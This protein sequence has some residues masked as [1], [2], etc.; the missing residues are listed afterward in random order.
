MTTQVIT[1]MAKTAGSYLF[2]LLKE[3]VFSKAVNQ[4]DVLQAQEKAISEQL[5]QLSQQVANILKE[6]KKDNEFDKMWGPV[7]HLRYYTERMEGCLRSADRGILTDLEKFLGDIR[8][9]NDGI[10]YQMATLYDALRGDSQ[11]NEFGGGIIKWWVSASYEAEVAKTDFT[12]KAFLDAVEAKLLAI[13][14]II[15][16][17]AVLLCTTTDDPK[18]AEKMAQDWSNKLES[19][20][21]LAWNNFPPAIKHFQ[22]S[23]SAPFDTNPSR[24]FRF[25]TFGVGPHDVTG[26]YL[27]CTSDFVQA[28]SPPGVPS[29]HEF[30]W[31]FASDPTVGPVGIICRKTGLQVSLSWLGAPLGHKPWWRESAVDFKGNDFQYVTYRMVPTYE[32]G[33]TPTI[34][35][36]GPFLLNGTTPSV[37]DRYPVQWALGTESY[38]L[39]IDEV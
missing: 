28:L 8:N 27:S 33:D 20:R 31:R 39:D 38:I 13:F 36:R 26:W 1:F 2:D 12:S 32:H 29:E 9:A 22:P 14:T 24:W 10:G 11:F 21:S 5:T 23:Y 30:Q 16:N 7:T 15:Q 37:Q 35:L 4:L 17:A 19:L 18:E 3:K 25:R 34:R 6:L